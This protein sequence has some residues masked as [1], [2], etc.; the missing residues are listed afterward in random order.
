MED[1]LNFTPSI[2]IYRKLNLCRLFLNVTCLMEITS[3][4][5]NNIVQGVM[6]GKSNKIPSSSLHWTK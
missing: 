5:G 2:K 4:D 6:Q 3:I 1:T